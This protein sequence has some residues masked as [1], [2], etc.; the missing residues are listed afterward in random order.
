[1]KASQKISSSQAHRYNQHAIAPSVKNDLVASSRLGAGNLPPVCGSAIRLAADRMNS[2]AA[3]T[4][5]SAHGPGNSLTPSTWVV[6]QKATAPATDAMT[7]ETGPTRSGTG[8]A[9]SGTGATPSG[10]GATTFGTGAAP[11]GTGA[12]TFGTGAAPSGTGATTFGT[13]AAPSGTGATTFGTATSSGTGAPSGTGVT[14][15][16]AGATTAGAGA[17][18]AGAGVTTLG[19]GATTAGA[20]ATT[21]G[22]GVTTLGAGATT[23]GAGVT[24]LGAGATTAGAGVTTLGAGATTAGAGVTTLGA[25]VTT[26]GAAARGPSLLLALVFSPWF[27]AALG[28]LA[29]GVG[30]VFLRVFRAG[31]MLLVGV[32]AVRSGTA[33]IGIGNGDRAPGTHQQARCEHAN[34]CSEAQMRQT[35]DLLPPA[36]GPLTR[37]PALP[38]SHGPTIA[39]TGIAN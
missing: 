33:G 16:G 37:R 28:L 31:G 25:G 14:T 12:T 8:A 17:T 24:T 10:T 1:M 4:G 22:A 19:A 11:S 35:H 20:G 38:L 2:I 15:L 26:L 39:C 5:T 32:R 36:K 21:A 7:S 6:A 3:P 13:G 29:V 27:G 9:P 23:A 30:A 18:T 34:T